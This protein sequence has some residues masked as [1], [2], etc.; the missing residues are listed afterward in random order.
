MDNITFEEKVATILKF[1]T[2]S[3]TANKFQLD[4]TSNN[5]KLF[6]LKNNYVL[7][8]SSFTHLINEAFRIITSTKVGA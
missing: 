4:P 8:N 5:Y 7:T 1:A 2:L 6:G 3:F